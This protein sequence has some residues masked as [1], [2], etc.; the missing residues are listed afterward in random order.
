M[1]RP[2]IGPSV[3]PREQEIVDLVVSGCWADDG[4]SVL[5][6]HAAQCDAC[7]ET[8][9]LASLL[10]DD[11]KLL[12]HEAP[13]PSA[14]AVWWRATIRARAEAVRTAGQ[15]ITLVQGIAAATAVGLFAGLA[16]S[17]WR[18]IGAGGAWFERAGD[19]VSRSAAIQGGLGLPLLLALAAC[20]VIGPL[21]V[22]L[23]TADE[24]ES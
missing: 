11:W 10:R 15:P 16:G 21:A 24:S 12:C 17:W 22:Y 5:Q 3:C 4:D 1:S 19:L 20:L 14:G 2:T 9:E 23:A 7:A 6:A 8:L 13:A 18:S